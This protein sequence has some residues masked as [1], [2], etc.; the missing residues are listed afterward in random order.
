[1]TDQTDIAKIAEAAAEGSKFGTQVVKTTEKILSGIAKI[2]GEPAEDAAGIIGDRLKFFRWERQL[3]YIVRSN[4]ILTERG[5]RETRAVP[6]KFA[7]PIITH[8]S[9]EEDDKLQDLWAMLTANAMD[10]DFKLELR[11]AYLEIIK[12]LNPLDVKILNLF[13]STLLGDPN[14]NWNNITEYHLRKEQL[15]EALSISDSD[16]QV[17]MFNLFRVQCM[18]PA[19]LKATNII[20][21][22]NEN[23]SIYKG[24]DAVTMTPL[25]V[26]FVKACIVDGKENNKR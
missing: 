6:P 4:E 19:V 16:Y 7:L 2:L 20:L 26:G 3:R 23:P 15:Q 22:N 8:A 10:P 25:G 5:V 12:S 11:Y 21:G 9:V 1:M 18:A 17:S 24:I 13:Y 14:I